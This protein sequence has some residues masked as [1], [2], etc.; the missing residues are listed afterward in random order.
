MQLTSTIT[1]PITFVS[2]ENIDSWPNYG[3]NKA[4]ACPYLGIL[5]LVNRAEIFLRTKMNIIYRFG[6]VMRNPSYDDHFSFLFFM[7][8]FA[9]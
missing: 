3:Q 2:F 8:L 6:L 1:N 9:G 7:P 4:R 5:I